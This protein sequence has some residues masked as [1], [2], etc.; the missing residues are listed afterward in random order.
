MNFKL[1]ELQSLTVMRMTRR[2]KLVKNLIIG[3]SKKNR[4]S[5]PKK[6]F[7]QRNKET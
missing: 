4:E 3:C 6:T 1:P 7:E 5:C 2:R